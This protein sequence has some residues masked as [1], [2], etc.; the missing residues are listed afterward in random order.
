MSLLY[1]NIILA[2]RFPRLAWE[3]TRLADCR[4]HHI[5]CRSKN[6]VDSRVTRKAGIYTVPYLYLSAE[7]RKNGGYHAATSETYLIL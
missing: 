3:H 5:Y 4:H 1:G 6:N 7:E 2:L